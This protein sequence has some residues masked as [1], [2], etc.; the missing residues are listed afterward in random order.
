MPLCILFV[1]IP[2]DRSFFLFVLAVW[3]KEIVVGP[4]L[5]APKCVISIYGGVCIMWKN[6]CP[7]VYGW[8]LFNVFF[9]DFPFSFPF[10]LSTCLPLCV[11]CFFGG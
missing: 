5:T 11:L 3:Q 2:Q 6:I 4:H 7:V 10:S 1:W 8:L 9:L